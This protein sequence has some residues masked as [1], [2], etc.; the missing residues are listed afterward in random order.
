MTSSKK[1][2][3]MEEKRVFQDKWENLYFFTEVKDKIQCLI[4]QQMIAV[5]KEYKVRRHYDTMHRE[6]YDAFTGK[7]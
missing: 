2:T 1:R 6:K 7:I 3:L 4:C 5:P